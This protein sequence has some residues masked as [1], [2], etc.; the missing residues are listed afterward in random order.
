MTDYTLKGTTE[1]QRCCG[2]GRIPNP[3]WDGRQETISV[4]C[5]DCKGAG[6]IVEE[7]TLRLVS[8]VERDKRRSL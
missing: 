2:E 8:V 6:V 5:P 1:C 7:Y 3:R 4:L